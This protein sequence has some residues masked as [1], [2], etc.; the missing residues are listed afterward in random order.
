MELE[1]NVTLPN[2]SGYT[3]ILPC[4]SVGNV[5]QLAVDVVLATLQPSLISQVFCI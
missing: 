5:G 2:F 3:L 4:V 1:P